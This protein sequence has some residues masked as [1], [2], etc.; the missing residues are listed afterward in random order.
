MAWDLVQVSIICNSVYIPSYKTVQNNT[1]IGKNKRKIEE[2]DAKKQ[3]LI[4]EHATN[5]CSRNEVLIGSYYSTLKRQ[6]NSIAF[7]GAA[8]AI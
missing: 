7:L 5:Q 4:A 3:V 1:L 6:S 2:L 8:S